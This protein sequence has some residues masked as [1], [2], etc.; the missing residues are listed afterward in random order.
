MIMIE[1]IDQD[2]DHFVLRADEPV[3]IEVSLVEAQAHEWNIIAHAYSGTGDD[4]EQEPDAVFDGTTGAR[5]E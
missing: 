1:V 5:Q 3:R 2:S 4:Q